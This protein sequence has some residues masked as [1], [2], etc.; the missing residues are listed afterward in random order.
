MLAAAIV[1]NVDWLNLD[2]AHWSAEDAFNESLIM[3]KTV[4]GR[5]PDMVAV[6]HLLNRSIELDPTFPDAHENLGILNLMRGQQGVGL[7]KRDLENGS[8]DTARRHATQTDAALAAAGKDAATAL[9]H[10]QSADQNLH[11]ALT[12]NASY[13]EAR[14]NRRILAQ[15]IM[16]LP[17]LTEEIRGSQSSVGNR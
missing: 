9:S 8:M 12:I 1:V 11:R 2:D 17:P 16:N 14:A 13:Q 6:E 10:F 5:G 4:R 15:L 3:Q 7:V